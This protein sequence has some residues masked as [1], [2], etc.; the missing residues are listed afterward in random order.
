MSWGQKLNYYIRYYLW[1]N[2]VD[3]ILFVH[4]EK[5]KDGLFRL[6]KPQLK[7]YGIFRCLEASILSRSHQIVIM[8]IVFN[9]IMNANLLSLF[10]V[11]L[12]LCFSILE[13]PIPSAK[14]WKFLMSYLLTVVSLKFL[15]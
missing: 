13:N 7:D 12:V 9:F 1:M 4:L 10:I 15:Y 3:H 2:Y 6:K 5:R 14:F 8:V 11:L